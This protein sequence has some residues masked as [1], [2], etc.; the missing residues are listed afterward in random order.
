MGDAGVESPAGLYGYLL[1]VSFGETGDAV[2]ASE[3]SSTVAW[4][5][6]GMGGGGPLMIGTGMGGGADCSLL[7][8][9]C[10]MSASWGRL[11]P[12]PIVDGA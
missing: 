3:S 5:R 1:G 9:K 7:R 8:E 11:R 6:T 2:S 4:K 10:D 12:S